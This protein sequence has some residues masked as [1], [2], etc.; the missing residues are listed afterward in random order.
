MGEDSQYNHLFLVYPVRCSSCSDPQDDGVKGV[1]I[2][3]IRTN[4]V[5]SI[6]V[7][8]NHQFTKRLR[9]DVGGVAGR[10]IEICDRE[11]PN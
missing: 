5:V 3:T 2:Y 4:N 10:F 8:G 11:V 7:L 6:K 1:Y 9:G